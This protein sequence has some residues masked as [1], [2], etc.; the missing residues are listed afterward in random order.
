MPFFYFVRIAAFIQAK[1][2]ENWNKSPCKLAYITFNPF[3]TEANAL[4]M[5][6]TRENPM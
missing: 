3:L 6:T 4:I 5:H 2:A 1:L